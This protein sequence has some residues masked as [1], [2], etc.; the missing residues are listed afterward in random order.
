MD[1]TST[2]GRTATPS[3]IAS[4]RHDDTGSNNDIISQGSSPTLLSSSSDNAD[5]GT[6]ESPLWLLC[7]NL[8]SWCFA[9]ITYVAE[10]F[11]IVWAAVHYATF[12]L[13][14]S[15][16]L[17]LV[18]YFGAVVIN[19]AISLFWYYDLDRVSVKQLEASGPFHGTYK[20]KCS[21]AAIVGHC[22]LL[23]EVYR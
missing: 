16:T 5:G 14:I 4:R 9:I 11:V 13:Y 8:L 3:S 15:M 17:T 23:G 21:F 7:W 1:R 12:D 22:V 10:G 18:C 6:S 19:G 2:P 20:R